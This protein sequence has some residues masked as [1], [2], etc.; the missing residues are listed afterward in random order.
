MDIFQGSEGVLP[1]SNVPYQ[2]S[3]DYLN[4][5]FHFKSALGCSASVKAIMILLSMANDLS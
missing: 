3:S 2:P 5:I 4:Q 1:L